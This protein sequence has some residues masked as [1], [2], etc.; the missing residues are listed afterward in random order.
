M[1]MERA[2]ISLPHP[3]SELIGLRN[4]PKLIRSPMVRSTTM[5]PQNKIIEGVL[6]DLVFIEFSFFLRFDSILFEDR[7][8]GLFGRG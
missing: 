1:A 3:N 8:K 5:D 2:K 6:Q 7:V 4:S